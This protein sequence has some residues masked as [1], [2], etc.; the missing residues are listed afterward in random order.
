MANSSNVEPDLLS[1]SKKFY[2]TRMK[3]AL[4]EIDD[5]FDTVIDNTQVSKEGKFRALHVSRSAFRS[6][7]YFSENFVDIFMNHYENA[8]LADSEYMRWSIR[9]NSCVDS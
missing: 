6:L 3:S 1:F 5:I 9:H 8:D 2:E 7:W 4:W